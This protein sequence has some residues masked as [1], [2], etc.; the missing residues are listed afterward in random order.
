MYCCTSN[1]FLFLI[2][3]NFFFYLLFESTRIRFW[4]RYLEGII[5]GVVGAIFW[6]VLKKLAPDRSALDNF[7]PTWILSRSMISLLLF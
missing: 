5:P 3:L 1:S 4:Q 6:S 2:V 7:Y